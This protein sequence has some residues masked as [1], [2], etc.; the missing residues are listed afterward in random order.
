MINLLPPTIK[1]DRMYGRRNIKL[2]SYSIAILVIGIASVGVLLANMSIV[3]GDKNRLAE[4][5]NTRQVEMDKLKSQQKDIDKI[6]SQLKVIDK[7]YSGEVKFS[8]VVPKIGSLL[9]SGMI[10]NGLSLTGGK[11]SPLQLDV[12]MDSQ[13]LAATFQQNLVGSDMFEA[14][15]ISSILTK[16]CTSKNGTKVYSYGATLSA[17]FKGS[18]AAKKTNGAAATTTTAPNGVKQ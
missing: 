3:S 12:D 11:T 9:P 6:A 14:A 17:S 4:E 15:D 10:L 18:K 13:Q 5:M 16:G 2:L 7:L 1:H 8:E